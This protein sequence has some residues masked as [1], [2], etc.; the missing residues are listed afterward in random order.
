LLN[1]LGT[2]VWSSF[3]A[4]FFAFII[5][6]SI[7]KGFQLCVGRL[8]D[9]TRP[10]DIPS[11]TR[12]LVGQMN[13]LNDAFDRLGKTTGIF[14]LADNV[15]AELRSVKEQLSV[16]QASVDQERREVNKRLY[17]KEQEIQAIRDENAQLNTEIARLENGFK[18]LQ[19]QFHQER[20]VQQALLKLTQE[21]FSEDEHPDS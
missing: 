15:F 17:E 20:R 18:R 3:T 10:L 19:S 12:A 1:A 16:L 11:A 6:P 7:E 2:S 14:D 4:I 8:G 5:C 9:N 21:L 13:N